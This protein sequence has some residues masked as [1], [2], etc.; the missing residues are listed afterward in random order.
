[1][2][3]GFSYQLNSLSL[4]LSDIDNN[5]EK[6]LDRFLSYVKVGT[7][8][9]DKSDSWPSTKGQLELGKMLVSE[10]REIGISDA[11]ID[12]NG[13]VTGTVP[14][15]DSTIPVIGFIAHLDT[16]PEM[17]GD[18][19][20]PQIIPDYQGNDI[21]LNKKLGILLSP[22]DFPELKNY[23]GQTLITTD[24]TTLLGADNKAGIAEIITAAEILLEKDDL[25]RGDVK[26]CFTPDEE[27]GRGANRF[28]I[29]K[30]GAEHAYTVDGGEAGSL[31]YETFNAASVTVT[32]QGRSIH[33]GTAKNQM[34]NSIGIAQEFCR[35]LP[36][37]EKP[38]HTE[39]YEGYFHVFD[40]KG[41]VDSTVMR[42]LIRDHSEK[43]FVYRKQILREI[44]DWLNNRYGDNVVTASIRDEYYNMRQKIEPF[45]HVVKTA[46]EA[47]RNCGIKPLIT[48]VRG[49]TDGAKLSYMGLPCPNIFTGGHN[50][51]GKY[52]YISLESMQKAVSV[53][54]EI[55]RLTANSKK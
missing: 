17:P 39:G 47:I 2:A 27:I 25:R 54:C 12:D 13:Y 40:F 23:K 33:P 8:S 31:E 46:E 20:R 50:F 28:N 7:A 26:I 38:E 21:A 9:D 24:G 15:N 45:M 53:I 35:M 32:V 19:V 36:Q 4:F 18:N 55:V 43:R 6:L 16:S 11:E 44:T 42:I 10:M 14:G 3:A 51:H 5:M 30:F 29:E 52:E 48:P 41:S 37:A 1:V 34:I 22:G 49:G